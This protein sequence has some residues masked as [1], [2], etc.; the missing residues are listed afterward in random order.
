MGYLGQLVSKLPIIPTRRDIGE[1]LVRRG[2]NRLRGD[3]DLVGALRGPD[4]WTFGAYNY[5]QHGAEEYLVDVETGQRHRA[6]G[7]GSDPGR[8]LGVPFA[9]GYQDFGCL[10]ELPGVEIG[11]DVFINNEPRNEDDD[12]ADARFGERLL[13]SMRSMKPAAPGSG[14]GRG[15]KYI[16]LGLS[17]IRGENWLRSGADADAVDLV[18][19][20]DEYWNLEKVDYDT[21]VNW[22]E[23]RGG[24]YKS[25]AGRGISPKNAFGTPLGYSM[26]RYARMFAPV[27]S[28]LARNLHSVRLADGD[29]V[30]GG[31]FMNMNGEVLAD[32]GH[33]QAT[34]AP[35]PREAHPG[36]DDIIVEESAFVPPE[37][38][39]ML[40]NDE[41]LQ[42]QVQTNEERAK[43]SQNMPNSGMWQVAMKYGGVF[44]G[45][46]LGWWFGQQ[47]AG[48]G[49]GGGGVSM[50]IDMADQVGGL[51]LHT[52]DAIGLL[53]GVVVGGAL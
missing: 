4:G 33:V 25:T 30:V 14:R 53:G 7:V 51:V 41:V 17:M 2:L 48:S 45:L 28:R 36:R 6:D 8:L 43:T 15:R 49:G 35:A 42:E 3:A 20:S 32:G 26:A 19:Y 22:Y 38:A 46:I 40:G 29:E 52:P 24:H 31:R 39:G 21:D 47:S 27:E 44:M 37:D 13:G 12:S 34:D 18:R 1:N 50:P 9:V 16:S 23:S 5:E 10:R 11:R